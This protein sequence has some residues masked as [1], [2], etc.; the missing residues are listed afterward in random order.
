[1]KTVEITVENKAGTPIT[2]L[3]YTAFPTLDKK[4]WSAQTFEITIK[5]GTPSSN[6]KYIDDIEFYD[7]SSNL[8]T[9]F[10]EYSYF[11]HSSELK[12]K[13]RMSAALKTVKVI[14][15]DI[16]ITGGAFDSPKEYTGT[17]IYT[18]VPDRD[19]T[20]GGPAG[21]TFALDNHGTR[22]INAT[23]DGRLSI[24]YA[25][26]GITRGKL[27]KE[28]I[29][30]KKLL[31]INF[32]EEDH[33]V[34]TTE[35]EYDGLGGTNESGQPIYQS[36][37]VDQSKVIG[38]VESD[39]D[40]E[41]KLHISA[42]IYYSSAD[43][44]PNPVQVT[45]R[46]SMRGLSAINY[47]LP[48]EK[49]GPFGKI[50]KR[51]VSVV[52]QREYL[53]KEYDSK[54][55]SIVAHNYWA[56]NNIP[57]ELQE[58]LP[59][60]P[61]IFTFSPAGV[62]DIGDY[63]LTATFRDPSD[64]N[65]FNLYL[66]IENPKDDDPVGNQGFLTYKIKPK[67]STVSY[68]GFSEGDYGG[69]SGTLVYSPFREMDYK[70]TFRNLNGNI[71]NL[72]FDYYE[73]T[74][75]LAEANL[76]IGENLYKLMTNAPSLAGE[77]AVKIIEGDN[78]GLSADTTKIYYLRN[79]LCEFKILKAPQETISIT[80]QVDLNFGAP[81]TLQ[82]AGGSGSGTVSYQVVTDNPLYENTG[83][84]QI[85]A[86]GGVTTVKAG[87]VYI[88]A[89]KAESDNYNAAESVP[90]ALTINKVTISLGLKSFESEYGLGAEMQFS[91]DNGA[92]ETPNGFA[93]PPKVL[94]ETNDGLFAY[95]SSS[96]IYDAGVYNIKIEE[97]TANSISYGYEFDYDTTVATFT[98]K[99]KKIKVKA[100]NVTV[101]YGTSAPL[102]YTVYSN[103]NVELDDILLAGTLSRK[104][105]NNV[106]SYAV[107]VGNIKTKNPNYDIAFTSATY[108]IIKAKLVV[109]C[110][111][112]SKE[113]GSTDPTPTFT[114]EG[115]AASDTIISI[116]LSGVIERATG[117]DAYRSGDAT[118]Y[119]TYAYF[120]NPSENTRFKHNSNNYESN[121]QFV[122]SVLTIH[123][124]TPT[125]SN[126]VKVYV[127]YGN[128]LHNALYGAT[129]SEVKPEVLATAKGK[130]INAETSS[131]ETA[132]IAGTYEWRNPDFKPNFAE[133]TS[134]PCEVLF[135]PHNRNYK[136]SYF[137]INVL[138]IKLEVT[139]TFT[140][141]TTYEY[142]GSSHKGG[143]RCTFDG[144]RGNDDLNEVIVYSGDV[145]DVGVYTATVTINQGNY[146]LIGIKTINIR[147]TPKTLTISHPDAEVALGEEIN[148]N[149]I[150]EGFISGEDES[151]LSTLPIIE[152]PQVVGLQEG[153]VASHASA[154]NYNIEYEPF[155]VTV[156]RTEIPPKEEGDISIQGVFKDNVV[157]QSKLVESGLDYKKIAGKVEAAKKKT[158]EISSTAIASMYVLKFV[159]EKT[160]NVIADSGATSITITLTEEQLAEFKNYT[161]VS[162]SYSGDIAVLNSPE[163]SEDNT[164][165]FDVENIESIVFLK[166]V[167]Q[168]IDFKRYIP[169]A[170]GGVAGIV[171]IAVIISAI[172][173]KKN[174]KRIIKFRQN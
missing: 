161:I 35:K 4:Y 171:I 129:K 69:A 165:V 144:V 55:P 70:A 127:S 95:Y 27:L 158:E 64:S 160:G 30:T 97:E 74:E 91:F 115:L 170:V 76:T 31:T 11:S 138:P 36:T 167:A 134:V 109:K 154:T 128:S 14:T 67:A 166:Q 51:A 98:V 2:D 80:S 101:T 15:G 1:V 28:Y 6:G 77:Y 156:L 81:Y 122:P 37:V 173:K 21:F 83:E 99:Q 121:V 137:T 75:N 44:S 62:S 50:N 32:T 105:G 19:L 60:N 119:R 85:G 116:G 143:I 155:N 111:P 66:K 63:E 100:S 169:I 172:V 7:S 13:V 104:P 56:G 106:G 33:S 43:V 107:T 82:T 149:F 48:G 136:R 12:V 39:T 53:Q 114:V 150:Y 163:V 8:I 90:F 112:M 120:V 126:F 108:Q 87:K 72:S 145:K 89:T 61:P 153:V 162:V 3:T 23:N 124:S 174:A 34:V 38:I 59:K 142:N 164:V 123:P 113:Y 159:D 52:I 5:L 78:Y 118:P 41:A 151:V 49:S 65:F 58:K 92:I 96:N 42:E 152:Y 47:E 54:N 93:Y 45:V 79:P 57:E 130:V 18:L 133:V 157:S 146:T 10:H 24:V 86:N 94:I 125:F 88:V 73:K 40:N 26:D 131:W 103:N 20:G 132:D 46:F 147:I 9:V 168:P 135:R 29:I 140:G 148:Y 84:I 17:E 68:V 139:V 25:K 22:P 16:S 117:E 110:D 71:V 141:E 102:E